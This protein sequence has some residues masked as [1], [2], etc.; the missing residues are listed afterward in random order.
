MYSLKSILG[1][2]TCQRSHIIPLGAPIWT[3]PVDHKSFWSA[4]RLVIRYPFF[5]K[6]QMNGI[7]YKFYNHI[8]LC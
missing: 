1:A 7:D 8:S 3:I 4:R 5:A 6:L 2:I